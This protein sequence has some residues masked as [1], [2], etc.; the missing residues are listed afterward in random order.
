MS[1]VELATLTAMD[2]KGLH[3]ERTCL[4]L[5]I[6]P[7][8]EH[9]PHL[10]LNTDIVGA[11]GVARR[12]CAA[13]S[14]RHPGWTFLF[15]PPIPIGSG[16]FT[17]P[18]SAEVRASA[19][20]AVVEDVALSFAQHG[21]RRLILASHHGG[22][23]HNV[24]LETAARTIE[25]R[26]RMQVLS[27]A[28]RLIVDLYFNG[29]LKAFYREL[30]IPLAQQQEL[31]QDCHG[32][33]FETSE[34]L[35]LRPDLVRDGWQTMPAHVV[36]LHTFGYGDVLHQHGHQGYF[37]APA[38]ASA[39]LGEAYLSFLVGRLLPDAER[40]LAG[41]R[42]PGLSLAMTA[43]MAAADSLARARATLTA[44]LPVIRWGIDSR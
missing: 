10:P 40:F 43:V 30:D 4:V 2:V 42:I 20:R 32:G 17:Y 29:G 25:R 6:S 33:A 22:P 13:L 3:R 7:I 39:E 5:P 34:M 9:G 16:C 38:H 35:T 11:E 37:G 24:A 28:G 14:D 44:T 27:L 18:G 36:P 1:L 21:F 23:G 12:L 26:S 31:D 8:E 15:Y 19:V 41:R